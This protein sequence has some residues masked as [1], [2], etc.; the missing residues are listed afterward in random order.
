[1]I[2]LF[3]RLVFLSFLVPRAKLT[4]TNV[5][6]QPFRNPFIDVPISSQL[7]KSEY[8]QQI[9]CDILLFFSQPKIEG[10][11]M[12]TFSGAMQ[13]IVLASCT[14]K[15]HINHDIIYRMH[16]P[17]NKCTYI[18]VRQMYRNLYKSGSYS[19]IKTKGLKR[20]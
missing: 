10:N 4:F 5:N 9:R 2:K 16:Q 8:V 19:I 18:Y 3:T 7:Q 17:D 6:V 14:H 20:K 13:T 1:M 12:G 15:R 11:L